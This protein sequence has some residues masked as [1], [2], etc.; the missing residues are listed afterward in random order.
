MKQGKRGNKLLLKSEIKKINHA[1]KNAL[2]RN[3]EEY[4]TVIEKHQ[5]AWK[6][7]A[8]K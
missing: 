8:N 6:E 3:S 4:K 2:D 7:L 1:A 5:K